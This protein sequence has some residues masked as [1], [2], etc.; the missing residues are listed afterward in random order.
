MATNAIECRKC[1]HTLAKRNHNGVV[2]FMVGIRVE[3]LADG[4]V[5]AWC[6]CG[7]S[8]VMVPSEK[9]AA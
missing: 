5:V 4:R 1:S 9:R 6:P 8:R 3:M 2:K 7:A